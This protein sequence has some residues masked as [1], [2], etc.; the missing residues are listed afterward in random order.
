MEQDHLSWLVSS[1]ANC[2]ETSQWLSWHMFQ[3]HSHPCQATQLI[4]SLFDA[5]NE[6]LVRCLPRRLLVGTSRQEVFYEVCNHNISCVCAWQSWVAKRFE[7]HC[8]ENP[9]SLL[10]VKSSGWALAKPTWN[11]KNSTLGTFGPRTY[12]E[13]RVTHNCGTRLFDFIVWRCWRLDVKVWF[14]FRRDT[15]WFTILSSSK[16]ADDVLF[17]KDQVVNV[18]S[19]LWYQHHPTPNVP[20]HHEPARPSGWAKRSVPD[21]ANPLMIKHF[22]LG[23]HSPQAHLPCQSLKHNHL[24]CL[25]WT[26]SQK[27]KRLCSTNCNLKR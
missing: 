6:E 23:G 11:P 10:P 24:P 8:F 16:N 22:Q 2:F 13:N 21:R 1:F 27:F 15:D 3:G 12:L 5:L 9:T 7:P 19:H 18:V 20:R 4:G 17:L 25:C 26:V 14:E